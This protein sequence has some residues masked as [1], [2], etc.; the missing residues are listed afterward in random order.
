L[1]ILIDESLPIDLA[2]ELPGHE[3]TTVRARR[4]RGLR[5]G[6]L[7][8]TAVDA[9]FEVLL[10]ADQSLRH[11]QNLVKIGIAAV[12]VI[13]VQNRMADVRPLIPQILAALETVE[14]GRAVEVRWR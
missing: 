7:L 5:N 13:G 6:V 4:W 10:T 9:G 1:R 14:I 8:R 3:V 2:G 12:I 11:Q